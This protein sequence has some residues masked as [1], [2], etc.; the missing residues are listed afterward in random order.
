MNKTGLIIL[1]VCVVILIGAAVAVMLIN[2]SA[3][4]IKSTKLNDSECATKVDF[5][6]S[7]TEFGRAKTTF[8]A[9]S[10]LYVIVASLVNDSKCSKQ[11]AVALVGADKLV[12]FE[13]ASN[14]YPFA[15]DNEESLT[16]Y[17]DYN[18][19]KNITAGTYTFELYYG[20]LF[21]KSIEV[22]II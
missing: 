19:G 2:P 18:P 5:K 10:P 16:N 4:D 3:K 17:G 8:S 11:S 20:D 6:V 12:V 1:V 9:N 15:K 21:V 13:K 22:K 7:D 14:F